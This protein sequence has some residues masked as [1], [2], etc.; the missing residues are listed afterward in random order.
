MDIQQW[1]N[2]ASVVLDKALDGDHESQAESVRNLAQTLS[3]LHGILELCDESETYVSW[4]GILTV[5]QVRHVL[6]IG[7]VR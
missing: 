1:I 2:D 5:M 4:K 3:V 6:T 7:L